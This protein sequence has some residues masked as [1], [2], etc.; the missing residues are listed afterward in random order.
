MTLFVPIL[1]NNLM[2]LVSWSFR[3]SDEEVSDVHEFLKVSV[4]YELCS[5]SFELLYSEPL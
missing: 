2:R 5:L 4:I 3:N 1:V